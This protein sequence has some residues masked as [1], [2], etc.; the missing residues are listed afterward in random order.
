MVLIKQVGASTVPLAFIVRSEE[1][2]QSQHMSIH[3]RLCH[4]CYVPFDFSRNSVKRVGG[5]EGGQICFVDTRLVPK[6][7]ISFSY[8]IGC[9]LFCGLFGTDFLYTKWLPLSLKV[10][11]INFLVKSA[12]PGRAPT[13]SHPVSSVPIR[14]L[15]SLRCRAS[16][17][18][19]PQGRWRRA[20]IFSTHKRL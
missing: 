8:Q 19:R 6:R 16:T 5:W 11:I 3:V 14:A 17:F 13:R 18:P 10:L 7:A 9:F 15:R 1:C 4:S 12:D 20:L 2:S